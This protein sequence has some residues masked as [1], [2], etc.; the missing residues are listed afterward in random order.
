MQYS[1]DNEISK[2]GKGGERAA[3]I[4]FIAQEQDVKNSANI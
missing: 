2:K 1:F 4:D 3:N